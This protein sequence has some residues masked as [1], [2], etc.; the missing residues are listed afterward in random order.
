MSDSLRENWL[1]ALIGLGVVAVAAWFVSFA[2][3]R[4]SGGVGD[5]RYELIARFPNANGIAAGTDVRV[6]GLKVGAV[7]SSEL[8][9]KTYQALVRLSVDRAVKLPTDSSAAIT[10][11]GIL[12][13]TYIAL[14]PG[15]E[16]VMLAAGGE[17]IETQGGADMMGLIGSYVN[18]SGDAPAAGAAPAAAGPAAQ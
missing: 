11:E 14:S 3:A 13:G 16:P 15:G 5:E 4:T 8:D 1:E 6:S 18:R 9:P 7:V 12:G 2:Y 17:I 10:Q